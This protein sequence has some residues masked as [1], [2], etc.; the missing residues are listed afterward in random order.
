MQKPKESWKFFLIYSLFLAIVA[1]LLLGGMILSPSEPDNSIFLGLSLPRFM[2]ASGLLIAFIFSAFV[3]IKA[4]KDGIW[5]EQTSERWFGKNRLGQATTWLAGISSGLGWIGCFLPFYRAGILAVHW[6]RLRPAMVFLLLA[7][8]ATLVM[9][10]IKR[11]TSPIQDG[12]LSKTYQSSLVLFFLGILLLSIMLY[13]DFGVSAPEDYWYGAG[14][15]IL[16]T[17]LI[18][19]LVGGVLFLQAEKKWEIRRFDL[20]LLLLIYAITVILWAREPLQKSFLFIGPYAPNRVLYPFA[21]GALYDTAS[22]FA[23]I[24]QNFLF[25]NGPFFERALYAS[26]LVVLHSLLGQDYGQLMAA[27]AAMFAIFPALVYLIGRSLNTRAIGFAAALIAMFRGANSIAASNMIDMAN[28][29]MMLTDFPTAIGVALLVLLTCNWL[30]KPH[31]KWYYALWIGGIIGL[32]IMLRTN[33][34]VFLLFI[35]IFVFLFFPF[36]WKTW[37]ASSFL[38]LLAVLAVTLPWE[39]RNQSLGGEMYSSLITKFQNVIDVRYRKPLPP[40]SSVPQENIL[41]SVSLKQ[42]QVLLEI[43]KDAKRIQPPSCNTVVCFVPNHFLHNVL[44]SI[45]VLP[46]SPVLDDLRHTVK[47]NHPYWQPDWDGSFTNISFLLFALNI[48]F[49]VLGI[50]VAW[51]Q[52]RLIGLV[53]LAIFVFYNLSNGFARTSGG[54]YIVPI[55]WIITIYFLIGVFQTIILVANAVGA[56][57]TLFPES[58]EQSAPK[59]SFLRNRLSNVLVTLAILFGVGSLVPLAETLHPNRY[60]DFD[61]SKAL[62]EHEAQIDNAGLSLQ[63]VDSFLQNPKATISVGRALYPRYYIENEGEV[64]FYPVV[65]MGFPRTT[66]TLIGNGGEK[67]IVLPGEKPNYFPHAVDAIVIGCKEKFY[68]DALAVILLDETGGV[69]TRSPASPLQCPLRQPVCDNNHNCY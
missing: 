2:L 66:F 21:D 39:L 46:T 42:T 8:V 10:F 6:D 45:L 28:P 7:S 57:W 61:I 5:A 34:V 17:Q 22:Q 3:A 54:R 41:A 40:E 64:H 62:S 33:A 16:V 51:K 9:V 36:Q 27:Q 11:S 30:R 52:H 48:F 56:G 1:I 26:F 37:I 50:T 12:K 35:P 29:K 59:Q 49:I 15:P 60:L 43:Y 68:V 19:A 55:D 47:E 4:R 25:Y 69:Y 24:G 67:G 44:T 14:V 38:I 20:I 18:T 13:T 53:P 31:Q 63:E 32:S 23:L 65:V 58:T